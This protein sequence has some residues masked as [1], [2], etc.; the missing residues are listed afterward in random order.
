M[1]P[2]S[3]WNERC[4]GGGG[5]V[6]HGFVNRFDAYVWWTK[7]KRKNTELFHRR[8]WMAIGQ[9]ENENRN[10]AHPSSPK[11]EFSTPWCNGS[12]TKP[13]WRPSPRECCHFSFV[14]AAFQFASRFPLD[15][16][17]AWRERRVQLWTRGKRNRCSFANR[18]RSY[19]QSI[20][21]LCWIQRSW[22]L[23]GCEN[24]SSCRP[25]NRSG[26]FCF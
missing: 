16:I 25:K 24:R 7:E 12:P 19:P 26:G 1:K 4:K 8:G 5:Y 17:Q 21:N 6:F 13:K 18:P 3:Y 20:R 22:R 23:R 14:L 15:T 11:T 10:S 2:F 9:N